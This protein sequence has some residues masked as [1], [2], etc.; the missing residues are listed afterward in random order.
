MRFKSIGHARLERNAN[1][2]AGRAIKQVPAK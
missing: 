2:E 1:T